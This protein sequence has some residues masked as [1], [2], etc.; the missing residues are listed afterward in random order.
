MTNPPEFHFQSPEES[1]GYLLWQVTMLWQRQMNRALSELDLTH[2]QFV[3]LATLGWLIK[4]KSEV[5]QVDISNHSNTDR[6]MVS[7]VIA[8]LQD[9][10]F[11]HRQ[12]HSTDTRAKSVSLTREGNSILQMA[13]KVVEQTDNAFFSHLA[14]QQSSYNN[15]MKVLYKNNEQS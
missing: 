7:K 9:K 2:T 6:M 12:E 5:T 4:D 1:S 3:I 11:V 10:N 8:N 15:M 14:S 13:L